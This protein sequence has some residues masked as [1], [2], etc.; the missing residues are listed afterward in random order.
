MCGIIGILEL[1]SNKNFFQNN[2]SIVENSVTV[3]QNNHSVAQKML[4]ALA[5][6]EYRGYDSAGIATVYN[7]DFLIYKTTNQIQDLI[8]QEKFKR[9]NG[10]IGIGHTRWATH[11]KANK[12]NCH[13]IVYQDIAV[14]H[15]GIIENHNELRVSLQN[16]GYNFQTETDTEVLA[17]LMHHYK[18]QGYS[19]Q[20]SVHLLVQQLKGSFAFVIL[21]RNKPYKLI[22]V[23]KESPLLVAYNDNTAFITSDMNSISHDI[24]SA[25]YLPNNSIVS[26]SIAKDLL[27]NSLSKNTENIINCEKSNEDFTIRFY[28]FYEKELKPKTQKVSEQ[29]VAD[30]GSYDTFMLK[31]I[32][33]QPELLTQILNK[34]IKRKEAFGSFL[35]FP[36]KSFKNIHIIG[37]GSSL[38]AGMI[39]R[40]YIE[41]ISNKFV[42]VDIASEF[43][44]K[45]SSLICNETLY[46][47]LSQ[48][49]ETADT[50]QALQKIHNSGGKT[51]GIVNIPTSYIAQNVDYIILMQVGIEIAVAATK[52][53]T[54][55]L[56]LLILF[57]MQMKSD[58]IYENINDIKVENSDIAV[59]H[60]VDYYLQLKKNIEITKNVLLQQDNIERIAQ[61]LAKAS[62]ILFIGRHRGYPLA[63]EGALKMKELAYIPSEGYA[64]GELKHGTIALIEK[65]TPVIVILFEDEYLHKNLST[66]EEIKAREGKVIVITTKSVALMLNQQSICDDIVAVSY[67][68]DYNI[69][70]NKNIQ[71]L[72]DNNLGEV[73]PY[74]VVL[75]MFAYYTA[76]ARGTNIDKPRN[77]AKSVTVE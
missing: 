29:K 3:N 52:S 57:A 47:L 76:K 42:S 62:Y 2:N 66:I 71:N 31:E 41:S 25:Y 35:S 54:A 33:E 59:N 45:P 70:C 7:E 10:N 12:S 77:L 23:R 34:I 67:D 40:Y 50:I 11:G 61:N 8:Q 64:S 20:K 28:D 27:L 1:N 72:S 38:Y 48:S 73:I 60:N 22:G 6:M 36:T 18:S 49:G 13:P 74:S 69:S 17:V 55:Q 5:F 68:Q 51:L 63:L 32:N 26:I 46:I 15:N 30:K 14:V 37:C 9:M 21:Q 24:T 53:F 43:C 56:L 39:A 44:S 58:L 65:D 4:N 19:C 16:N 75:Q